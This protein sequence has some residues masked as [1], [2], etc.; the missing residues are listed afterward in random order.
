[1]PGET[2]EGWK[3][4]F[5]VWANTGGSAVTVAGIVALGSGLVAVVFGDALMAE[6]AAAAVGG[7]AAIWFGRRLGEA[8]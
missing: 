8:A 7:L 4:R 2:S 5:L 6:G 1:M 3:G